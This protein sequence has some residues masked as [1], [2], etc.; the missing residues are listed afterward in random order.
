[1]AAPKIKL[2]IEDGGWTTKEPLRPFS[3]D[4]QSYTRHI[5]LDHQPILVIPEH[6]A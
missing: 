1:M 6:G 2:R 4:D 3:S 5:G